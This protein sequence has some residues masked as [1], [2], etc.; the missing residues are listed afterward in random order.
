M[1][2]CPY[3]TAS[4]LFSRVILG[5]KMVILPKFERLFGRKDPLLIMRGVNI[6]SE[7]LPP[8]IVYLREIKK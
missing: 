7:T 1:D 5:S 6:L 2:V 8:T 3:D 4:Y